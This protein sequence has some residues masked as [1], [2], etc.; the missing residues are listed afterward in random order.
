MFLKDYEIHVLDPSSGKVSVPQIQVAS[1]DVEVRRAFEGQTPTSADVSPD[2]KKFALVI[3][4]GLYV[5]DTK[6]KYLQKLATPS[7]ER[8]YEVVWGDD[9]KTVYFTRTDKGWTNL[10]KIPADGSAGESPVF[11]SENNTKCLESDP[12]REKMAFIDGDRAVMLLDMKA[13]TVV[14][15]AEAEFWSFE[16]YRLS[17]S[18]DGNWLAFDAMHMFESDIF[19]YNLKDKSL[20]NFTHSASMEQSPVFTPDGK[21]MYLLANLT[22]TSFP[23]GAR[24]SLYKLPL[25]KYDTPFVLYFVV[26]YFVLQKMFPAD[27]KH[28]DGAQEFIQEHKRGLGKWTRAQKNTLIAFIVAVV[29][30]VFPGI[31]NAIQSISPDAI[32]ADLLKNYNKHFPEAIA[33]MVGG[34]LL[35]I[36]PTNLKKGE[37]TLKWKDGVAGIDWGT[38]LLFGGGLAIGGMVFSTGLS[39]WIGESLT[40]ALGGHPSEYLFLT[41]FAVTALLLSELTS[42]TAVANI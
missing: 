8:V 6:C 15:V 20:R 2:G 11:I 40:S 12:K 25:R 10:Y 37:M 18:N 5:S 26:T 22:S 4:G 30:W 14:K 28:I 42:N 3:R 24:P 34:L 39:K 1:G 36:M 31:L 33:A 13:G 17:F 38:L 27:V 16:G 19:L 23:R 9:S 7:D 32:D 35:F 21:Y 41:L 29:L